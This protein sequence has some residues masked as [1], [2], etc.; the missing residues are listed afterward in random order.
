[1]THCLMFLPIVE[2]L[3][4]QAGIDKLFAWCD[5]SFRRARIR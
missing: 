5:I 3:T 1:M 2:Q 4:L